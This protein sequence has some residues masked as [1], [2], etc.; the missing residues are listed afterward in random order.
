MQL[1]HRT[2][3]PRRHE[4]YIRR[5]EDKHHRQRQQRSREI[6]FVNQALQGSRAGEE[7]RIAGSAGIGES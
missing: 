1:P 7:S 5:R 3:S 2:D 4:Q 6:G